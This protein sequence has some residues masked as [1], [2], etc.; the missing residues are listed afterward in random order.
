MIL[1]GLILAP[2]T[3]GIS[4]LFILGGASGF[5]SDSKSSQLSMARTTRPVHPPMIQKLI[6]SLNRQGNA[7]Q[8]AV[9]Q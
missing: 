6:N 4:L 5:F 7:A 2:F 3:L 9:Q 1:I 8:H